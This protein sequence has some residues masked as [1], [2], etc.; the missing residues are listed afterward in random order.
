LEA[1]VAGSWLEKDKGLAILTEARKKPV[2]DWM[3]K[4]YE[5][6]DAHLRGEFTQ[7]K[8]EFVQATKLKGNDLELFKTG[9][10]IY[11]RDGYCNTCHQPDG[12]GLSASGFPPLAGTKWV[13]GSEERLIKI[14]LKGLMGPMEIG[15]KAYAGQV[16]MTPFGGML[17]DRE[18]A[19]VLTYVRKSF[20]NDASVIS[21]EKVKQVRATT[22]KDGMFYKP[23]KLLEEYPMEK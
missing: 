17:N 20:G 16:P 1:V 4:A 13:T 5:T 10:E 8:R 14:V 18:V 22:E 15:G 9:K 12:L 7:K 23:A 11:A 3:E 19:A 6:T 21:P 2:D